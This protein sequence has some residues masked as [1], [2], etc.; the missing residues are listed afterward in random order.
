LEINNQKFGL[1]LE[2]KKKLCKL[3]LVLTYKQKEPVVEIEPVP[4]PAKY[5]AP[6]SFYENADSGEFPEDLYDAFLIAE[7]Q[8]ALR[9]DEN[10]K[11]TAQVGLTTMKGIQGVG[12][13]LAATSANDTNN[14]MTSVTSKGLSLIVAK[15]SP[16]DASANSSQSFNSEG[17]SSI[18]MPKLSSVFKDASKI[19]GGFQAKMVASA[20]NPYVSSKS[21]VSG[22]I[23]SL[24][25]TD[26]S[27]NPI[28]VTNTSE[29]FVINVPSPEPAKGFK[30]IVNRTGITYHKLYLKNASTVVFVAQPRTP[31]D[32]YFVYVK[33]SAAKVANASFFPLDRTFDFSFALPNRNVVAAKDPT[34]EVAYTVFIPANA[35]KDDATYYIG[36]K[37]ASRILTYSTR[38]IY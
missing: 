38:I 4:V 33:Y 8:R 24:D 27:G 3:K 12:T 11:K 14:N 36:V 20:S 29:P 6:A 28:A 22:S 32:Q 37:L 15:K 25:I 35:T 10:R 5:A 2:I 16:T 17:G 1:P 18:E 23:V 9:E 19:T 13:A 7:A 21:Q 31:G 34:G 26:D 30:S